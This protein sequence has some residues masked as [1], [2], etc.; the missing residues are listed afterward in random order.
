M[1]NFSE[2]SEKEAGQENSESQ[3]DIQFEEI[4]DLD[5]IQQQLKQ[6]IEKEK[7]IEEHPGEE[8]PE[9]E[10]SAKEDITGDINLPAVAPPPPVEVDPNA[11]KYVIYIDSTNVDFM[12]GL[13]IN[14]RKSMINTILKEQNEAA[15]KAKEIARRKRFVTHLII[16]VLTFII[17]FP[18]IFAGV[19]K[20]M[21]IIITN[22][23]TAKENFSK[24]Y[25][26]HG[27]IKPSDADAEKNFKY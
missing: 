22:Y 18:L 25:K 7:Y 14:E 11:K 10:S 13:S 4:T 12:E 24:L 9:A 16:A 17:G 21:E 15:I 1:V 8:P 2:G 3:G 19:N 20:A 23:Q 6:K 26:E 27:K 5:A